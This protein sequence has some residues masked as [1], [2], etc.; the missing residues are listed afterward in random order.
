MAWAAEF[1]DD[2]EKA[3]EHSL[4]A[5]EKFRAAG[6]EIREA[7][8]SNDVGWRYACLGRYAEAREFCEEAT[9]LNNK[10]GHAEGTAATLDSLAHIAH[11]DGRHADAVTHYREALAVY[12]ELEATAL[13]A[14]VWSC[15]PERP[16]LYQA[17]APCRSRKVPVG[18]SAPM[19][20]SSTIA[21]VPSVTVCGPL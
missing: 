6:A 15:A 13:R 14:R 2:L 3:L 9:L 16:G 1:E 18:P 8:S 4:L 12:R 21:S 5:L 17:I 7:E 19:V 10:L 20:A 11:H